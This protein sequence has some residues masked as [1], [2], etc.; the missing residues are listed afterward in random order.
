MRKIGQLTGNQMRCQE[1]DYSNMM[2]YSA[3]KKRLLSDKANII[4]V[5]IVIAKLIKR[6]IS[7]E[8]YQIYL[9]QY[10]YFQGIVKYLEESIHEIDSLPPEISKNLGIAKK[11]KELE[12]EG[13]FSKR[14]TYSNGVEIPQ[15]IE[16]LR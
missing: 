6:E 2:K 15:G 3:K 13:E 5:M 11:R 1:M 16:D 12:V 4:E 9:S 7:E 10:E 14:R 8:Q